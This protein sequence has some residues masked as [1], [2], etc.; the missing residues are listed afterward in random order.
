[1]RNIDVVPLPVGGLRAPDF[2][3]AVVL[4][5]NTAQQYTVPAGAAFVVFAADG[6][7]YAAYGANPTAVVPAATTS[8]G[9]SNEINPTMRYVA[10]I[11]KISLI[12]PAARVVTLAFYA[13]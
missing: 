5:A 10:G 6:N 9:T 12:A 1:M 4:A 3:D 2:V 7:F 11:A 8:G 13:P